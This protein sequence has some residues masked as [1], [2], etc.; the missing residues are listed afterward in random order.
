MT[1]SGTNSALNTLLSANWSGAVNSHSDRSRWIELVFDSSGVRITLPCIRHRRARGESLGKS[2][3]PPSPWCWLMK[4][5][6]GRGLSW[7]WGGYQFWQRLFYHHP[8]LL[9]FLLLVGRCGIGTTG[10]ERRGRN[11]VPRSVVVL[12]ART[13]LR[14]AVRSVLLRT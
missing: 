3:N 8:F 1:D 11:F 6:L 9:W 14:D 10:V 12:L 4:C 5:F 13:G 7:C 2:I